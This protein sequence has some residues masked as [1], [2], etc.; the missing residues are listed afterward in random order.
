MR[1]GPAPVEAI[2][3]RRTERGTAQDPLPGDGKNY[4]LTLS[5]L[6]PELQ[7]PPGP[8]TRVWRG[9]QGGREARELVV[10]GGSGR[11]ASGEGGGGPRAHPTSPFWVLS[12]PAL[13]PSPLGGTGGG[14]VG[15]GGVGGV[16][17]AA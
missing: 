17:G 2:P 7:G 8:C 10:A 9:S 11:V 1:A 3:W 15:G 14:R 6:T 4:N 16:G 12:S 13:S 5:S